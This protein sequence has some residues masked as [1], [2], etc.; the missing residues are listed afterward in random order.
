M[1]LT[2][3]DAIKYLEPL[4]LL[5][6]MMASLVHDVGHPGLNNA[7]QTQTLS[8]LAIRYNDR[9]VLE[10]FHAAHGFELMLEYHIL[11]ALSKDEKKT[12]RQ[13]YIGCVL[14]TD[15]ALHVEILGKWN[16]VIEN[17]DSKNK[18]HRSLLL[19]ILIKSSDISN[20]AKKFDQAKYW[21][22]M[23]QEE[24]FIQGDLEKKKGLPVSPFCDRDSSDLPKM[25]IGFADFMVIP[26]MSRLQAKLLPDIQLLT[27]RLQQ[28]KSN[29]TQIAEEQ[30]QAQSNSNKKIDS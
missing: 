12:F 28:N 7:F 17:F 30:K 16:N 22:Y 26:M 19:Q 3:G 29:W 10:N 9:N 24:F 23:I 1:L 14:A 25:Q 2:H 11:E 27:N 6:L 4:E 21:A 18:E 5:V 20:P 13:L 8:T 15:L